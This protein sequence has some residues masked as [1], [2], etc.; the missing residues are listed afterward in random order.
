MGGR[1]CNELRVDYIEYSCHELRVHIVRHL[2][3]KNC[4]IHVP[5]LLHRVCYKLGKD[6]YISEHLYS[7]SHLGEA[8]VVVSM[9]EAEQLSLDATRAAIT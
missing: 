2:S 8:L 1:V 3:E 9:Q 4:V 5:D 6:K 7:K